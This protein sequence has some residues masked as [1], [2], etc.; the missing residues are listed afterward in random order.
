MGKLME[1]GSKKLVGNSVVL[2]DKKE[3]YSRPVSRM[4][5]TGTSG[6]A[7][8]IIN[9][10]G[11]MASKL[12]YHPLSSSAD[13]A[14]ESPAFS[15]GGQTL[16]GVVDRGDEEHIDLEWPCLNDMNVRVE[17]HEYT[18]RLGNPTVSARR[19]RP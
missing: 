4:S 1:E 8:D 19:R 2:D 7:N 5:G 15:S 17:L 3:T 6:L 14:S 10:P 13:S 12:D 11:E 16:H 9:I 18:P